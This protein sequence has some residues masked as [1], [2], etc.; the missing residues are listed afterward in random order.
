M[1][2][3]GPAL[4]ILFHRSAWNFVGISIGLFS[5]AVASSSDSSSSDS[6][7]S[8]S[9][10]DRR[11]KKKRKKERKEKKSKKHKK[12]KKKKKK[13]GKF[14]T[15]SLGARQILNWQFSEEEGWFWKGEWGWG[16]M[17]GSDCTDEGTTGKNG[18]EQKWK[19][20]IYSGKGRGRSARSSHSRTSSQ[21]T[22]SCRC[23]CFEHQS[24]V[25]RS[26]KLNFC[27]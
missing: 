21:R 14:L 15:L 9:E 18:N 6:E 25:S 2:G 22:T 8:S 11:K 1:F 23:C 17:G 12:D 27:N 5:E 7:S 16:W 10:E 20:K 26:N 4:A 13:V 19:N 24:Q 3:K